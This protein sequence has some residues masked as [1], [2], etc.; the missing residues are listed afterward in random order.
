MSRFSIAAALV[1][2]GFAGSAA[3]ADFYVNLLSNELDP[4]PTAGTAYIQFHNAGWNGTKFAFEV[5]IW[6][7]LDLGQIGKI[8][9]NISSSLW[10]TITSYSNTAGQTGDLN[11]SQN[12]E[13]L[14]GQFGE[15]DIVI[16]YP[17]FDGSGGTDKFDINESST[18]TFYSNTAFNEA[19]AFHDVNSGNN[20][21]IYDGFYG[22]AFLQGL[23]NGQ[24]MKTGGK[25][26]DGTPPPPPGPPDPVPVPASII[27]M[28]TAGACLFAGRRMFTLVG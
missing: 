27:G 8:A 16:N 20:N 19:T 21:S 25:G 17:P 3:K 14:S 2:A 15:F 7:K 6:N 23:V 9:L 22:A 26:I 4:T 5:T 12:N 24:S 1:V 28:L 11:Y 10:S 13:T 18:W